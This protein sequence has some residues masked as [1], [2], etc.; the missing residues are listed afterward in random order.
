MARYTKLSLAEINRITALY[1][2]EVADYQPM[3]GGSGNSNYRLSTPYTEYVLTVFDDKPE[4][5]VRN[6]A[7]LLV[8]LAEHDFPT[9][10]LVISL[11]EQSAVSYDTKPTLLNNYVFEFFSSRDLI[12]IVIIVA[13]SPFVFA[14]VPMA[15]DTICIVA[16]FFMFFGNLL[17]V[18]LMAAITGVSVIS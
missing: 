18:M 7:R 3:E 2:F 10:R 8:I 17:L 5:H 4:E 14:P 16:Y 11:D 12:I 9:T 13:F 6:M 1:G 15:A